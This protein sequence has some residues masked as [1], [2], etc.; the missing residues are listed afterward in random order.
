VNVLFPPSLSASPCLS[1]SLTVKLFISVSLCLSVCVCVNPCLCVFPCLIPGF[2]NL[3]LARFLFE[4]LSLPV[5]LFSISL[6]VCFSIIIYSSMSVFAS[7]LCPC[8]CLWRCFCLSVCLSLSWILFIHVELKRDTISGQFR[9]RPIN[10][11]SVAKQKLRQ[12]RHFD[13]RTD[14]NFG[15]FAVLPHRAAACSEFLNLPLR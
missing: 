2:S 7:S 14:V 6:Y 8:L 1:I 3:S 11:Q 10:L 5:S 9:F 13:F 15:A 4:P 12:R